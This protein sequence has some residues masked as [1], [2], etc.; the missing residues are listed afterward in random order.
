MLI[1]LGMAIGMVAHIFGGDTA[2]ALNPARE[3]RK[4]LKF[5]YKKIDK[6]SKLSPGPANIQMFN[7]SGVPLKDGDVHVISSL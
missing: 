1:M 2:A 7:K 5:Y 4:S 6:H 3:V